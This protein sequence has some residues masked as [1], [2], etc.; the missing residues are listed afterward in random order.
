MTWKA[1]DLP[2]MIFVDTNILLASVLFDHEQ[3][4]AVKLALREIINNDRAISTSLQVCK[5][6]YQIATLGKG[7]YQP[8]RRNE[9]LRSINYLVN[10]LVFLDDTKKTF[11]ILLQLAKKYKVKG[12]AIHEIGPI[13]TML[14]HD[15]DHILTLDAAPYARFREIIILTPG[16]LHSE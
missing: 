3:Y 15:I 13:A 11:E 9:V 16:T 2:E 7:L 14:S 4:N 1:D 5:E 8:I 6:F 10:Q 12:Q